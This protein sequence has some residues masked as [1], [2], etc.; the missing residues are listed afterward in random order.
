MSDDEKDVGAEGQT[1]EERLAA[2]K[3]KRQFRKFSYR[4]HHL[5]EILSKTLDELVELYPCRARRSLFHLS[6][7]QCRR[8]LVREK[9]TATRR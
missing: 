8:R 4:G 1:E 2:L 3:K 9:A 6:S 5:D 7:G